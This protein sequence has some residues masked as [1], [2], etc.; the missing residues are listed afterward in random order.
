MTRAESIPVSDELAAR[1]EA[2][3]EASGLQTPAL[4]ASL[5]DEG[6]KARQFPG[7]V[8]MDGTAG[9][10]ASLTGGPDVWQVIRALREVP[11]DEYDPVD[12]VCIE[13]DLHS[14]Q[15]NLAVQFY[16]V[17]P[18]EIEQMIAEDLAAVQLIDEM[19]AERDQAIA[20]GQAAQFAKPQRATALPA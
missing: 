9:R 10:R 17:Y 4:A 14:R 15:V 3:S 8:Y 16:E 20:L 13:S 5:I 7:I 6:L 12:T 19:I 1:L 18:D 11:A 2:A